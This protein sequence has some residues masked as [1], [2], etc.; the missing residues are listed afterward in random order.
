MQYMLLCRFNED[1]WNAIPERE[2]D[3]IMADYYGLLD[4]LDREG[5]HVAT[6]KLEPVAAGRVVRYGGGVPVTDGPFMETKEHLGGFHVVEAASLD[7]ATAI[8]ARFPT[9]PHGGVVEVRP[10]LEI[11]S[12]P[13]GAPASPGG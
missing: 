8:A 13:V 4:E 5:R 9:L 12:A 7:A 10:L 11:R 2:R 3:R 6:G 1:A